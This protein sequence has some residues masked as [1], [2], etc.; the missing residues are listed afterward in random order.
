MKV[1]SHHGPHLYISNLPSGSN[2]TALASIPLSTIWHTGHARR[3][4]GTWHWAGCFQ[5]MLHT[6]CRIQFLWQFKAL[7]TS[8]ALSSNGSTQPCCNY[9]TIVFTHFATPLTT[10]V[11]MAGRI[12]VM[13]MKLFVFR[14]W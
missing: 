3:D 4:G 13:G 10:N 7:A 9:C 2:Y 6:Q 5:V 8:S 11:H 14:F 12:N 1:Y